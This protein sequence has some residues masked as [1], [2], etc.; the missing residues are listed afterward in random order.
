M[1]PGR[2]LI[3]STRVDRNTASLIEWVMNSPA[4]PLRWNSAMTSSLRRSRVISSTALNG[5]SN[6]KTLRFEHQ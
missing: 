6:R 3:T 2:E 5:S 1:R 4:K